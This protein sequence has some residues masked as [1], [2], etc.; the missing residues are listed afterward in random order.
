MFLI[1]KNNS[2]TTIL[3]KFYCP[4][5]TQI[6]DELLIMTDYKQCSFVVF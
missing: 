6:M 5:Y 3:R 4:L 2:P 1:A